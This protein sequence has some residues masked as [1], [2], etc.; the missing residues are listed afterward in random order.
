[1]DIAGIT[2]IVVIAVILISAGVAL[3]RGFIKEVLTILGI[4]GGLV[5]AF[6]FGDSML[7]V[8]EGWL[9]IVEGEDPQKLFDIVP[10]DLLAKILSYASVLIVFVIVLNIIGHFLSKAISSAGLGAVDRTLGVIFGILRGVLLLGVLYLPVHLMAPEK[11][12]KDWFEGS[13]MIFYLETTAEWLVQFLPQTIEEEGETTR[14]LLE[15][16]DVLKALDG[17]GTSDE[18]SDDIKNQ[19]DLKDDS[20]DGQDGYDKDE[21]TGLDQL[22]N[23]KTRG[24]LNE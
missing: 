10:Y 3:F 7:P 24:T 14:E 11:N 13:N 1:M 19:Y 15:N 12:K 17:G 2:D 18:V 22:I 5:M 21:R 4:V 20:T 6:F 9:G 16:M 23:K 8:M